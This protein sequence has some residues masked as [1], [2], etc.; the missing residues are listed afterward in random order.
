MCRSK[1]AEHATAI[2]LKEGIHPGL[3]LSNVETQGIDLVNL[4]GFDVRIGAN[5]VL[6]FYKGRVP[7]ARMDAIA[8]GLAKLMRRKQGVIAEVMVGGDIAVGDPLT[9]IDEKDS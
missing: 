2:G 5:V 1:I 9:V 8:P 7:C 4:I 6:R 3:V